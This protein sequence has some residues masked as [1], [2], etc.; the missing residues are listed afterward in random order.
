M[1]APTTWIEVRSIHAPGDIAIYAVDE[2]VTHLSPDDSVPAAGTGVGTATITFK[3]DGSGQAASVFV[4]DSGDKDASRVIVF[5]A[6][7]ASYVFDQ[8]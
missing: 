4:G 3:P 7:G 2:T 8:W 1:A 6:S 5:S